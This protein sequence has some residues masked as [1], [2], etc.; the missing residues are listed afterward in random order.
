MWA[1]RGTEPV[2]LGYR[3]MVMRR[4][5]G[6]LAVLLALA[7]CGDDSQAT[8]SPPP[9]APP[10]VLVSATSG[11][12]DPA[13]QAT[14]VGDD[15]AL[16]SYVEQFSDG[17]ADQVTAAAGRIE[18]GEGETLVAQVVTIGCD[19]PVRARVSGAGHDVVL[20]PTPVPSPHREC[21]APVT[22]VGLA[23]VPA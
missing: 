20:V 1:A 15:A 5:L 9:D 10:V 2:G 4:L 18:V 11:G 12:G 8:D 13:E 14:D 21:F 3:P 19:K 6:T 22:T 16:A 23:A 17:F 7:G